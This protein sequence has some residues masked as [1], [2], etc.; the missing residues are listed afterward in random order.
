M[1]MGSYVIYNEDY[2]ALFEFCE[3]TVPTNSYG[4]WDQSV[5]N[6]AL[7]QAE[8]ILTNFFDDDDP[9]NDANA[10]YYLNLIYEGNY[11]IFTW[12]TEY[13]GP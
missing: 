4:G 10:D 7:E 12:S 2:A 1:P 3:L 11:E 13:T 5:F 9:D 8:T 6:N